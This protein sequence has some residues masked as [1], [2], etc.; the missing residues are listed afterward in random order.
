[1]SYSHIVTLRGEEALEARGAL[2]FG[3]LP[4]LMN[5]LT[6]YDE[7]EDS[8]IREESVAGSFDTVWTQGDYRAIIHED[9]SVSLERRV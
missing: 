6:E 1:M 8:D 9:R 5:Y 3:G 2:R 4:E 7:F